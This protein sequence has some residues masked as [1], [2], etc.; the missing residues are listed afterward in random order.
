MKV[1]L[2]LKLLREKNKQKMLCIQVDRST[3]RKN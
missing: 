1:I 3:N 2:K